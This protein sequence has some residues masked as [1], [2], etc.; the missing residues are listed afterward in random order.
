M[1]KLIIEKSTLISN[2]KKLNKDCYF[3][4]IK[5][6]HNNPNKEKN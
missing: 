5:N 6:M 2:L 4:E 1:N 3:P